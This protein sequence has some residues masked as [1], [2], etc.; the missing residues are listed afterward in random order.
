MRGFVAV[1]DNDWFS[2]LSGRPDIDE[3]NFW[4]PGG[5]R[6]FRALG[7]GEPFFFKL[8]SPNNFIV[9]GGFFTHST[10]LPISLAWQAFQ[11]KN[12]T[13]SLHEMRSHLERYRRIKP[14]VHEDYTVGCILLAQP[15]FFPRRDW[16]SVPSDFSRNI[17]QGKSYD[18]T[19]GHGQVLWDAVR[20]RLSLENS[21][22]EE[23]L[24]TAEPAGS[25]GSPLVIRPRLGQG[26]FRVM[27]TDAYERRCAVTRE[28]TLPAL[29]AAHIRPFHA[30]GPH[31]VCNG[32][33]LRSDI[34]RLFDAGYVTATTDHR[35]EVSRR[36][37][38]DFDNGEQYQRLHGSSL[39]LPGAQVLQPR[40]EFLS[41]HNDQIFKG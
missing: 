38:E 17:V 20:E 19:K 35:F 2:F 27:V 33:L 31:R 36:L 24:N 39:H 41:W 9:G 22:N 23:S 13:A 8:H 40:S 15:F 6:L 32:L 10:L 14:A 28:R 11:E 4:Q 21:L 5:N 30:K 7:Q 26:A 3:V 16:I 25:Y 18:L 34:H 12:G 1:T 29:E 37:K